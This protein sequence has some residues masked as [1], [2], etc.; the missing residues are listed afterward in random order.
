VVPNVNDVDIWK[1]L[2]CLDDEDFWTE[3]VYFTTSH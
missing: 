1:I 3:G 2:F